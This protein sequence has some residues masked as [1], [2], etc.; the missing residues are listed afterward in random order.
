MGVALAAFSLAAALIVLLPGP[1]TLVV[2]RELMRAGRRRAAHTVAGVLC[3]LAVWVG[4]AAIGLSALLRASH[5][6]YI[7]LKIAGG[8]YLIWLGVQSLRLR[9]L[10]EHPQRRL[11]GRGFVAGFATDLLNPKVGVFFVT[12][13]PGFV[14]HGASVGAVSV[15]F[16]AIF[17]AETALYFVVLL[18]VAT[19][20]TRWLGDARIRRRMDA[21]TGAVLI[22]LGVRLAAEP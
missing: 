5:T 14:P 20:V 18:A 3:G 11:L 19:P 6:G 4:A 21:A 22:G 16:G 13:L 1:D 17:I 8:A 15:L 12:F 7:V 2:L 9:R 10:A